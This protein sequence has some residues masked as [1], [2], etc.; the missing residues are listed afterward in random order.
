MTLGVNLECSFIFIKVYLYPC[1]AIEYD[2]MD[3]PNP[4]I[5]GLFFFWKEVQYYGYSS[6]MFINLMLVHRFNQ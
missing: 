1:G 3:D 4:I 2:P 6:G 5:N